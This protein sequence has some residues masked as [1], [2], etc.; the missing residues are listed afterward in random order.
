[1]AGRSNASI[2]ESPRMNMQGSA[3]F[4]FEA[5]SVQRVIAK[6]RKRRVSKMGYRLAPIEVNIAEGGFAEF[7]IYNDQG[8]PIATFGFA[9]EHE[10]H[11]ARALMIRAIAKADLIVSH[12]QI[13]RQSID[14]LDKAETLLKR[15]AD[16]RE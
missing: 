14:S 4:F 8:E 13:A 7:R 10:A 2:A 5:A 6:G 9:D 1:V 3:D 12:T 16:Y 15:L 11:I